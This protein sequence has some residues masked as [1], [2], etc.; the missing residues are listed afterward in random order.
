[1][2][3]SSCSEVRMSDFH[4]QDL[5]KLHFRSYEI[6]QRSRNRLDIG[7]LAEFRRS[8]SGNKIDMDRYFAKN[9]TGASPIPKREFADFTCR[10]MQPSILDRDHDSLFGAENFGSFDTG[11][12]RH[13]AGV[14]EPF[15][16]LLI[17]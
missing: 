3:D 15:S 1:M 4:A 14:T 6:V 8:E 12:V 10:D 11:L 2:L 17:G 16:D 5:F 9:G 13:D 7:V